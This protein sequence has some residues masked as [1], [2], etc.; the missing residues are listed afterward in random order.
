MRRHPR[1]ARGSALVEALLV[2]SLL[3]FCT[4]SL[5]QFSYYILDAF[6][7]EAAAREGA[8]MVHLSGGKILSSEYLMNQALAGEL[9]L[10][11]LGIRVQEVWGVPDFNTQKPSKG[12]GSSFISQGLARLGAVSVK[13]SYSRPGSVISTFFKTSELSAQATVIVGTWKVGI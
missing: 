5:L 8:R 7:V 6:R 9:A 3:I 2:M 10:D 4:G 13:I 11:P 12:P 1:T